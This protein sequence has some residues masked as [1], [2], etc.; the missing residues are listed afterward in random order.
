MAHGARGTRGITRCCRWSMVGIPLLRLG[1]RPP[2]D[3]IPAET[4]SSVFAGLQAVVLPASLV[5][6]DR[7]VPQKPDVEER[8]QQYKYPQQNSDDECAHRT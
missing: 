3:R 4:S 7:L 6:P 5:K 1:S 2:T 8:Y